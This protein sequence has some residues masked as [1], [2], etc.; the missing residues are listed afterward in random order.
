MDAT[1]NG[2]DTKTKTAPRRTSTASDPAPGEAGPVSI[3]GDRALQIIGD[4]RVIVTE[5]DV[6]LMRHD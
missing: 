1:D 3:R 5:E 4:Q 6:G 2:S